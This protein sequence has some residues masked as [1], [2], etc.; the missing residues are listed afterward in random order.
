MI[1][2]KKGN[3]FIHNWAINWN[4]VAEDFSDATDIVLTYNVLGRTKEFP[5]EKYKIEG[6][7]IKTE[8]TPEICDWVGQY[9]LELKY[10][11]PSDEFS[12]G[13]RRSAVDVR[14]FQIVET[15]DQADATQDISVTSDA[16]AGFALKY[17]DLTDEQ[18]D[19]LRGKGIASIQMT[20]EDGDV[21]TYTITYTDGL[22]FD[23]PVRD[24][25]S[26]VF[27]FNGT[28][29]VLDGV[30]QVD[31]KGETGNGIA[32]IELT[33]TVG[34]V[35]TYTIT[36][37]DATTATFTV[38]D[39]AAAVVQDKGSN[40]SVVMSQKAVTD[41]FNTKAAHGYETEPKTLKQVD[42]EVSQLAGEVNE[43]SNDI[44]FIHANEVA[45]N[46][47][48]SLNSVT[49]SMFFL[50]D[51]PESME[52]GGYP[53]VE[54]IIDLVSP[55]S[56]TIGYLTRFTNTQTTNASNFRFESTEARLSRPTLIS[57]SFWVEKSQF[58][59]MNFSNVIFIASYNPSVKILSNSVAVSDAVKGE[60]GVRTTTA[61]TSPI[62][63]ATRELYKAFE[64]DGW[65]QIKINFKDI[66]WI[67]PTTTKWMYGFG[68][69]N[70]QTRWVN[71]SLDYVNFQIS[72]NIEVPD[73]VVVLRD[74]T[75]SLLQIPQSFKGLEKY[76]DEKIYENSS[77]L[78]DLQEDVSKID[79]ITQKPNKFV[80]DKSGNGVSYIESQFSE[81]YDFRI[82]FV[83]NSISGNRCFGFK[84]AKL[85]DKATLAE[86]TVH[87]PSD[88]ITPARY[89]NTYIGANH[90]CSDLRNIISTNHGKTY[91]D[92]GSEWTNGV[93]KFYIISI[94]DANNI[95]ILGEN[96]ESYPLWG[97][98]LVENGDIL[99]HVS[100]ATN[101]SSF[102]VE[103]STLSQIIPAISL[104]SSNVIA[105]GVEISES[106]TYYFNEL[107]VC[108]NYDVFNAAS[109]L[110]RI[111]SLVGTFSANPRY[112]QLGAEKV[113]RHSLNY[114][115]T[116]ADK[117]FV[118]TN[119]IAYQDINID[120]FGFM[121]QSVL[122]GG[123]VKMYIP[124]TLPIM[125]GATQKDFRTITDYNSLDNVLNITPEY[126]ENPLLPPDR[127]IQKSNVITFNGGFLFDYGVG[128]EKRKDSVNNAF[129]LNTTRKVYP[130][131]IDSK[132]SVPGGSKY[133]SVCF[134]IYSDANSFNTNGIINK[135]IFEYEGSLYCY[136][137]FNG[138]GYHE[139]SIPDKFIGR[140]IQVFEKS[141]NVEVLS[142]TANSNILVS[143]GAST[144][145]YGYLVFK[146]N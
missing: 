117:C 63:N 92:I 61:I 146:I 60:V 96:A 65:C 140:T 103:T 84:T 24:G 58:A 143:V 69:N 38:T 62:I 119:F 110:D 83:V 88:D 137:D 20:S 90:G 100:G 21:K 112:N 68:F 30:P 4:G 124:K 78:A 142:E 113:V 77:K 141:T 134:R 47:V 56:E 11:K 14:A 74:I 81:Q 97:F 23:F 114:K 79:V 132:I 17:E 43:N 48:G 128:G 118:N 82:E 104:P 36:F 129:F 76:L 52:P 133:A 35:K 95:R 40:T 50:Q 41:E 123:G 22:T 106:G 42:D 115:F 136:A 1:K 111:K 18:K 70:M 55:F 13:E 12:E 98:R 57:I 73:G 135:N 34:L 80:Y 49:P 59:S 2:I 116:S 121:Q 127:Y 46:Q 15:S 54:N 89:N 126:W 66:E 10:T 53:M 19:E 51:A 27:S 29:L 94:I 85:I 8:C 105:D 109:I 102:T 31:L 64:K 91:A 28:T 122:S 67:I 99:T 145:L 130:H 3:S 5:V 101:T 86:L 32:S 125:D 33:S 45:I 87:S 71:A 138:A 131:G 44:K 25:H 6:N 139:V 72:E 9:R 144:P 7:I 39:G 120:Y 26:P 93:Y 37:T 16:V 108:E 75:N 107:N